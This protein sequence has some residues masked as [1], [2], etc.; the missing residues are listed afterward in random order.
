MAAGELAGKLHDTTTAPS[1][2]ALPVPTS[3]IETLDGASGS[4]KSFELCE[5]APRFF[6]IAMLFYLLSISLS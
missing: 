3:E 4:K 5:F 2:Y 6:P 1:L